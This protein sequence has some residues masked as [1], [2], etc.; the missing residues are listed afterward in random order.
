[1]EEQKEQQT[2][3]QKKNTLGMEM[4][5][6]QL[7]D[8]TKLLMKNELEEVMNKINMLEH[9]GVVSSGNDI[10]KQLK[11]QFSNLKDK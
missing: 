11:E 7:H 2:D 9:M 5:V 8:A 6:N 4:L 3:W 1:M 10:L